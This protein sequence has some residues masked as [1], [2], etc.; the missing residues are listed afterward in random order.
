[1]F[2]LLQAKREQIEAGRQF[3]ES[4]RDYWLARTAYN[5]TLSG[6]VGAVPRLE[7]RAGRREDDERRNGARGPE[8]GG[9]Q[10]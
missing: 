2:Q 10:R 5:Q 4:L 8:P 6:R 7:A 9:E 3:I 1:V